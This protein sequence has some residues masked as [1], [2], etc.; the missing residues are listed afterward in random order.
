MITAFNVDQRVCP[1]IRKQ[2][3]QFLFLGIQ[4]KQKFLPLVILGVQTLWS[5]SSCSESQLI[6]CENPLQQN[7]SYCSVNQQMED[8]V[9]PGFRV[10]VQLL[11]QCGCRSQVL[12]QQ[13]IKSGSGVQ[14]LPQLHSELQLETSPGLQESLSDLKYGKPTF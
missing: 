13:C 2:T 3:F 14:S 9:N 6:V 11:A 4:Q 8:E 12:P 5:S 10:V 1:E 7:Y